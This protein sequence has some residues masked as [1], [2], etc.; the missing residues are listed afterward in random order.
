[1]HGETSG[2]WTDAFYES[3]LPETWR[4]Y[5]PFKE[6]LLAGRAGRDEMLM[7]GTTVNSAY[8]RGQSYYPGTPSAGC[9]VAVESWSPDGRLVKSDQLSLAKA[10][11]SG[12][13]DRGY[14]VVV[15]IDDRATP[16]MIEDVIADVLAAEALRK[17]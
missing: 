15:E 13:A 5:W 9:L 3:F 17:N 14:L 10:F 1:V 6:A 12:G 8:Y 11:T 7:H 16:V 2:E 4:G